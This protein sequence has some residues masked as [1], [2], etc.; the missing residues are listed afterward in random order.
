MFN[1]ELLEKKK[2][3]LE[4]LEKKVVSSSNF[5]YI[6]FINLGLSYSTY[7]IANLSKGLTLSLKLNALAIIITVLAYRLHTDLKTKKKQVFKI[8]I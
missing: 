8:T 6:S 7:V 2:K 1:L 3:N 5:H 4:L